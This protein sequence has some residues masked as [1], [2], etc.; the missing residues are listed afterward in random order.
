M[1]ESLAYLH[2]AL[3]YEAPA[4]IDP[5]LGAN[6]Y[7]PFAGIDQKR[8]YTT[9]GS[10]LLSVTLGL[11]ALNIANPAAAALR[12]GDSGGEVTALQQRLRQMGYFSAKVTG[13]FGTLT[14]TA[15]TRFQAA[16]GLTADGIVGA[17][18]E[19]ALSL[20]SSKP[21]Q[22]NLSSANPK[23][24]ASLAGNAN[25]INVFL[26]E[27]DR[28]PKVQELQTQLKQLGYFQG[29]INGLFG[30]DTTAALLNFQRSKGLTA[31]GIA[32]PRTLAA[33]M[34]RGNSAIASAKNSSTLP[35]LPA[36]PSQSSINTANQSSVLALQ[37]RLQAKG[38]YKGSLDG[39]LGIETKA[40]LEAAQKAYGVGSNNFNN[41]SFITP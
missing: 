32:G 2:L 10:Y 14:T 17:Q 8:F 16:K 7:D 4:N 13:Y 30:S 12:E 37:K 15:V 29:T 24:R 22:Q 31:D 11:G 40:A 25:G 27:G 9:A 34:N 1:V 23:P 38:F 6:T 41:N 33:V 18:T 26:Q 3:S 39:I 36:L 21:K 5:F 20:P 35:A 19:S 28:S